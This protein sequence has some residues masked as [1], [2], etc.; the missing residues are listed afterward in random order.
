[1]QNRLD[2]PPHVV[3]KNLGGILMSEESQPHTRP[4]Y[5]GFQCQEDKFP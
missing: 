3:D 2:P 5:P 4:S 1:M